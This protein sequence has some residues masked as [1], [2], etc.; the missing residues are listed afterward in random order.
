MLKSDCSLTA[1]TAVGGRTN[2]HA[3]VA[4]RVE[5]NISNPAAVSPQDGR[6][7]VVRLHLLPGQQV[8]EATVDGR[9]AKVVAIKP[10]AVDAVHAPFGGAGSPPAP[11]AGPIAEIDMPPAPGNRQA[12]VVRVDSNAHKL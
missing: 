2:G 5:L 8:A 12:A 11:L 4:M 6:G 9:A 10:A 7:W 1:A 3:E